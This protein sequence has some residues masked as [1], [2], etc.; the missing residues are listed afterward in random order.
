MNLN[1]FIVKEEDTVLQVMQAID[2]NGRRIAFICKDKILIAVISDGDIRRYILKKGSLDASIKEIANYHPLYVTNEEAVDYH[3]F[4]KER[5]IT[6]L[7]VVNKKKK[8]ITVHFLNENLPLKNENLNVPVVIMAGGKGTRLYP[9]TQILPKP[10]IPIGDKTITEIIMDHFEVFGCKH[11]DMIVNYKKNFIKSFFIDNERVRDVDFIDEEEFYGTGGGL[12]LLSGKYQDSF[13]VTNCDIVIEEDYADIMEHHKREKNIITIVAAM[14]ETTIPY[15][16]I[17]IGN[18]G[19]VIKLKEK[20]SFSFLTNTGL[21]VLEPHFLDLIPK[22]TF[23]HITDVIEECITRGEKVGI[24]PISEHAWMDM[25]Q[26][27][28]LEKMRERL[29]IDSRE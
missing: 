21:Y 7:P 9:Y 2:N 13:F 17:E 15:G 24:Y 22:N 28:E 19:Q 12:K 1:D 6:A 8:I 3:A 5:H 10:L 14:K 11:F 16:T 25:G 4:M 18:E 23:I 20:P 29:G 26:M 27:E